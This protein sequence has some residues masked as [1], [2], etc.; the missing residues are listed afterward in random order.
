MNYC[1]NCRTYFTSVTAF[2]DHQ[3][4]DYSKSRPPHVTCEDP[5]ITNEWSEA[6][7]AWATKGK[8]KLRAAFAEKT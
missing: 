8:D 1:S 7:Q 5:N 6:R 2:D 3:T 4:E